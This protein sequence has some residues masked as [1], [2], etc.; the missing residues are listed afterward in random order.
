MW[1]KTSPRRDTLDYWICDTLL[2]RQDSLR[3]SLTYLFTDSLDRVVPRTDTL[4]VVPKQ[5]W[6]KLKKQEQEAE[7]KAK[8]EREKR[9]RKKARQNCP[10]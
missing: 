4:T 1:W 3:F 10:Q 7:E 5:T 2:H 6:A 9:K 8:K